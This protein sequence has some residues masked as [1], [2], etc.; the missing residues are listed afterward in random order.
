M[1]LKNKC[2]FFFQH[3]ENFFLITKIMYI[4]LENL[5]NISNSKEESKNY[6]PP[7]PPRRNLHLLLVIIFAAVSLHAC[8]YNIHVIFN[9]LFPLS[10]ILW[11]SFYVNE[12]LH[13][14]NI[15]LFV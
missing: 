7:Q 3:E 10:S 2:A 12:N 8:N 15:R 14:C 9:L 13:I 11:S 4:Y 6:F 5:S 1:V